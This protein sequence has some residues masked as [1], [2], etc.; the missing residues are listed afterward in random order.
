M[1]LARTITLA[2][3]SQRV[4]GTPDAASNELLNKNNNTNNRKK[5]KREK[6]IVTF[7]I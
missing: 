6:V 3:A 4:E 7:C 2:Q 5:K 1:F